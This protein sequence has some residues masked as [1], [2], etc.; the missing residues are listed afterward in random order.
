[1]FTPSPDS[2]LRDFAHKNTSKEG[3][4]GGEEDA[5]HARAQ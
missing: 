3:A 2:Q 1:M 5:A 4:L